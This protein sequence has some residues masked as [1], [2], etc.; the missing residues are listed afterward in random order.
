MAD[1]IV[2]IGTVGKYCLDAINQIWILIIARKYI[3][4]Q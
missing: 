1:R 4:M 2:D 3:K